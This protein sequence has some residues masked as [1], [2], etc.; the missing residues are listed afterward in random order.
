MSEQFE[1]EG[2][3]EIVLL[4]NADGTAVSSEMRY[5]E[6]EALTNQATTLDAHAA[7]VVKAVYSIVGSGLTVRGLVFFL[8]KVNEESLIDRSFNVPLR[9]LAS[10][11]GV[12]PD[13]GMGPVRLACRGLCPVPWHSVNMW[14]PKGEG[15]EHP[16]MLVQKAV[17]RNRLSLKPMATRAIHD[18]VACSTLSDEQ[19]V[20]E[21]RLTETFG[22]EGKVSLQQLIAQHNNQLSEVG[23]KYRSD[24]QQQ[25]RAYLDQI[26]DCRDEIQKLKSTLR[27]EQERSRRLQGLLRGEP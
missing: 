23:Q 24:V 2:F 8:F 27:H 17:W 13:L 6:F 21:E 14:Q 15:D 7:S 4:F 20:L 25:Q 10:N 16:S 1:Q 19:L 22:E 18:D 3:E 11:A 5:T 12:G 26:R 9:Y